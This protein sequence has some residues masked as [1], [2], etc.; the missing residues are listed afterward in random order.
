MRQLMQ[1]IGLSVRP[2]PDMSQRSAAQARLPTS[3]TPAAMS[4]G[5]GVAQLDVTVVSPAL[6]AIGHSVGGG[7]GGLEWVVRA[8]TIAFE[9]CILTAGALGDGIRARRVGEGGFAIF[10]AAALAC[11]LAGGALTLIA[12][13]AVQG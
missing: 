1:T 7:G 6:S 11:G 2:R 3:L 8:Y 9:A 12:A 5:Y 13:R 4:L 10:T